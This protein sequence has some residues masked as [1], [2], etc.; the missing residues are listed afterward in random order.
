MAKIFNRKLKNLLDMINIVVYYINMKRETITAFK[1]YLN[2]KYPAIN[3]LYKNNQYGNK[4][5][6]YG[7]YLYAQDREMFNA[8]LTS[9]LAGHMNED[10][11]Y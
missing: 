6:N 7:D 8:N 5:R 10:F 3:G 2:E 4:T 9:T 11:K 1:K